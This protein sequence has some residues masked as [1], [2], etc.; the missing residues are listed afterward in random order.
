M[1]SG[2]PSFI[3]RDSAVILAACVAEMEAQTGRTLRPAQPE[4]LQVNMVAA[5][6]IA[7]RNGIQ[8]AGLQNLV[9]FAEFPALSFLGEIVGVYRLD[10]E[11]ATCTIRFTLDPDHTGIVI[12]AGTRV[13]TRDSAYT[14]LTDEDL[15]VAEGVTTGDALATCDTEGAEGNG[16]AAGEVNGLLDPMA[17]ILGAANIDETSGGAEQET[18]E[19]MRERIYA[20]PAQFSTAGPLEAYRYHAL[21]AHPSISD[22][23]II[24]DPNDGIVQVYVLTL[25]GLPDAGVLDAVEASM[26]DEKV[27]P[28]TDLVEVNAATEVQYT[29]EATLTLYETA[30]QDLALEQAQ[31]AGDAYAAAQRARLGL[32]VVPSQIAKVLAVEG[33]YEVVITS[34]AKTVLAKTEWA[35]CQAVTLTIA[36]T[37]EG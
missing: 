17:S 25:T 27:I 24:A 2:E 21:A 1:A 20:A 32:D 30:D 23:A 35:N 11:P 19:Q 37:A 4:R 28:L 34:P 14:F 29:I 26:S 10:A 8:I 3:E 31:A 33:I 16:Y 5:R 36:G 9:R 15:T 12:P 22:V 7:V 13:A 6:E 18:K